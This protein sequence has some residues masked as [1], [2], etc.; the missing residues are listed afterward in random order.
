VDGGRR[1]RQP[2]WRSLAYRIPTELRGRGVAVELV[3]VDSG[4][5]ARV[6]VGVD[7]VRITLAGD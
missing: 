4:R 7:D 1:S 2:R 6:E 3:A 5:D